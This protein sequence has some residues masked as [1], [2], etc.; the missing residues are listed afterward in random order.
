MYWWHGIL[1][2]DL[3]CWSVDSAQD[4]APSSSCSSCVDFQA[5]R[6][7]VFPSWRAAARWIGALNGSG[8]VGRISWELSETKTVAWQ[9]QSTLALRS[10]GWRYKKSD[11]RNP[12]VTFYVVTHNKSLTVK[13]PLYWNGSTAADPFGCLAIVVIVRIPSGVKSDYQTQ[14]ELYT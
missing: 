3:W 12:R 9:S 14:T 11:S 4:T 7:K 5:R 10:H 8:L 1:S 6:A 2:E 13:K